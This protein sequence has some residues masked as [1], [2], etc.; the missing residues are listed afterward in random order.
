[1]LVDFV[2]LK[3]SDR[4]NDTEDGRDAP[5]HLALRLGPTAKTPHGPWAQACVRLIRRQPP[6]HAPR[7]D[8]H[9]MPAVSP[10]PSPD[11]IQP[12]N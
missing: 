11:L 10:D 8:D 9:S 4:G 2:V 6:T 5:D 3:W 1:M 7:G 12:V